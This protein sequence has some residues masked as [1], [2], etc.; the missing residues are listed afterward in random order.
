MRRGHLTL[1]ALLILSLAACGGGSG[2]SSGSSTTYRFVTPV[3]NSSRTYSETIIDNLNYTIEAGFS[4][5]VT[6]VNPVTWTDL[7][8][9]TRTQTITNWHD[10]LEP[11]VA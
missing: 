6:A 7:Q 2:S 1:A 4:D 5:T 8:G 3:L 9:T 10:S 11:G